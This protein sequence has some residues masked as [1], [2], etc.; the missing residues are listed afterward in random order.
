M[1]TA[2]KEVDTK[3]VDK[4]GKAAISWAAAEYKYLQD[5]RESLENLKG[6]LHRD[7][8]VRIAGD[9]KR[10]RTA[11][12]AAS[13]CTRVINRDELAL[14]RDIE[15][16]LAKAPTD[17]KEQ[18]T[19]CCERI[20]I[21][22]GNIVRETSFYVGTINASLNHLALRFESA[23]TEQTDMQTLMAELSSLYER[24][25]SLI[26]F[27]RAL[28]VDTDKAIRISDRL[29]ETLS[30]GTQPIVSAPFPNDF[31]DLS[32][33]WLSSVSPAKLEEAFR[34]GFRI[35]RTQVRDTV[36]YYVTDGETFTVIQE[37]GGD[38][39]HDSYIRWAALEGFKETS[40]AESEIAIANLKAHLEARGV[41]LLYKELYKELINGSLSGWILKLVSLL[42]TDYYKLGTLTGIKLGFEQSFS[43]SSDKDVY[44]FP[45]G[46]VTISPQ[47]LGSSRRTFT[48]RF[49]HELGH[50][51]EPALQFRKIDLQAEFSIIRSGGSLLG[52][53]FD[54][55]GPEA[56][57]KYQKNSY[58]EFLA[59]VFMIYV[60]QG[61]RL[62]NHIQ[63][64]NGDV[65]AAWQ[66][67]YATLKQ[68]LHVEY[69]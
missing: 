67:V 19:H 65:C 18:L 68:A 40:P 47:T 28:E 55:K 13:K 35:E 20:K 58:G 45:P 24:V 26:D 37:E 15:Q 29:S 42:P 8:F 39:W 33:D 66:K 69:V 9:M 3:E 49:L 21:E 52:T 44:N 54:E 1:I 11:L 43:Y 2:T 10:I 51:L 30:F 63:S 59:E 7:S 17:V 38:K 56:R 23:R 36:L 62:R 57:I 46:S 32:K 14:E 31:V 41:G 53:D 64:L 22:L 4:H 60:S 27:V 61:P 6:H 50:A 16:F 12:R 25:C 5:V 34:A 48:A